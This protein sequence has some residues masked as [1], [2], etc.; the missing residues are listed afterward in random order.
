[1]KLALDDGSASSAEEAEQRF[2]SFHVQI[3]VGRDVATSR[4]LQAALV[5]LLNAAP[6]TFLGEV[7]VIGQ[8]D[9]DFDIGWQRGLSTRRVVEY[10]GAQCHS[11]QLDRPR[12]F[13]GQQEGDGVSHSFALHL[14]CTATGFMLSP[15]ELEATPRSALVPAGVAA[16]GAALSECFQHHYFRR[17]WAGLRFVQ[18]D[19]P[20]A[21]RCIGRLP[22]SILAIGLGHL[23]QAFLWTVGLDVD[24]NTTLPLLT[25]QDY[26]RIT[27]ASLSTGL[28]AQREGIGKLKVDVVA[29][30]MEQLAFHCERLPFRMDLTEALQDTSDV[31]LVAVDS[32][33]FRRQLDKLTGPSIVEGGIG[34][35]VDGFTKLQ[36][37]LLPGSR[38]AADIWAGADP[39]AT[40]PVSIVAPA[41]QELL[42][43]T[44][45]EC[46]ITQ[47]AGRS[48][49]TPFV[50][51]FGGALMFSI[52]SAEK[53]TL[54]TVNSWNFDVNHL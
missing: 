20:G 44:G 38:K 2:R 3:V 43:K 12:I 35:G 54:D 29:D 24:G 40:R 17:P 53:K 27:P 25:L 7:T 26:D 31:C 51:A 23:G 4:A 13:V 45:D 47:L 49:A 33:G 6:R 19:L 21:G 42:R 22:K 41:Y 16:A 30:A 15:D 39:R 18:F 10:Y 37:H 48:I 46:G 14:A 52:L 11:S 1:M 5:T 32:L 34:D 50:G 9:F 28:L 36:L 8:L